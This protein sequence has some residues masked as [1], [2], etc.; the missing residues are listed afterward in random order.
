MLIPS[1]LPADGTAPIDAARAAGRGL[2]GSR[3]RSTSRRA[4]PGRSAA[5]CLPRR[6]SAPPGCPSRATSSR[7]Q[8]G[9]P[10]TS[11]KLITSTPACPGPV[12]I[13]SSATAPR[14]KAF[15]HT[16]IGGTAPAVSGPLGG[17]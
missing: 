12:L 7:H 16:S 5:V 6:T 11:T 1:P 17:G 9:L 8:L 14:G 4:P 13:A 10:R 15:A 2:A 3:E